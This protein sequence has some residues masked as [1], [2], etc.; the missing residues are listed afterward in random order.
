M[1]NIAVSIIVL[2]I[3]SIYL[4]WNANYIYH[5]LKKRKRDKHDK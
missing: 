5:D 4:G 1:L 2:I 3:C